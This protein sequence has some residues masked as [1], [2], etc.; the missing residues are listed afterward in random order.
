MAMGQVEPEGARRGAGGFAAT[1]QRLAASPVLWLAAFLAFVLAGLS[2]RLRLPLG[3]NYWDTAIYLDA[4]QRILH[5]LELTHRRVV[6]DQVR[7]EL[8]RHPPAASA[9]IRP[10]PPAL[11]PWH[12]T[13]G[14]NR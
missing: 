7:E 5:D 11:A 1:A 14:T 13:P 8:P 4:V 6:L 12:P 3:P 10:R 2:L 9:P